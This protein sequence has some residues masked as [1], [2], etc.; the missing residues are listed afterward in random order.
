MFQ[1][2]ITVTI[3]FIIEFAKIFFYPSER[4]FKGHLYYWLEIFI[5]SR[6][7]GSKPNINGYPILRKD[8]KLLCCIQIIPE[9][10]VELTHFIAKEIPLSGLGSRKYRQSIFGQ[11]KNR[12]IVNKK[13]KPEDIKFQLNFIGLKQEIDVSKKNLAVIKSY[14]KTI[15]NEKRLKLDTEEEAN[16]ISDETL[17]YIIKKIRDSYNPYSFRSYIIKIAKSFASVYLRKKYANVNFEETS[18]DNSFK[19]NKNFPMNIPDIAIEF[20]FN[21]RK[22]YRLIEKN[23]VKPINENECMRLDENGLEKLKDLLK[24]E[25]II[26]LL[27]NY[28]AEKKN[29]KPKSAR[30]FIRRRINKGETIKDIAINLGLDKIS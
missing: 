20:A 10:I 26:G 2:F 12:I 7:E 29:I 27:K 19:A 24:Q 18:L 16:L 4:L 3:D 6:K 1:H 14:L 17:T 5:Y 15:I 25:E 28:I 9:F 22:I 23:K 13:T 11:Y 30:D 8:K 21:E